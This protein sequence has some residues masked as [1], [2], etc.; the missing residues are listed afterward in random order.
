[1]SMRP[2]GMVGWL[3]RGYLGPQRWLL[4]AAL[5]LM[6]VEG[7]MAGTLSAL[8]RPMFDEVF[9]G[10]SARAV[11]WVAASVSGVFVIRALA[12]LGQRVLSARAG[13]RLTAA[14]QAD[15]VAHLATLDQRFHQA[16]PPGSLI[17]RVR[18]DTTALRSLLVSI[19]AALGRDAVALVSLFGVALWIDWRW[20]LVAVAGAPLLVLPVLALQ[21]LVRRTSRAARAAAATLSTRLDEIFHGMVTIQLTG[22]EAREAARYRAGLD[23]YVRDQ[24]RAEAG[25]AG[26]PAMMDI[27]AAIGFAGVLSYGGLQ[28]IAGEK[29]VGEFMS[30]FTAMALIFEP[31]R[32][33]GAVSGSWQVALANLERLR[34]LFDARP[35]VV[36]P[37]APLPLPA[38][39]PDIR[40]EQ[41]H[42]AY[43]R[44]PVLDG[45]D[46]VAEAGQTTALVGPSGAGKTTVFSLISRLADPQRGTVRLGGCDLRALD[47][48]GLRGL[49]SV[50]SQETALFDETIRDNILMGRS[51]VSAAALQ[52]AIDAA[53][54][55]EFAA[56]LPKGLDTPAGPRGSALSGGQRQRVAI[57]RAIL[58]DTPVLLLDEATSALDAQSEAL[59]AEALSRL[60]AG[61]TTLVI[62]HR[63]STVRD[64]DRI[65]VMERGRVVETGRHEE[66]LAR[67]GTYAGLYRLQFRPEAG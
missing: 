47:L 3:W 50:V 17:E 62:A 24:V 46:F 27:V 31:M 36:T 56:Q 14:M 18:G 34:T 43:G 37:A 65:V 13:E 28:I 22:T 6:A 38:G 19:V 52:A 35:T 21:R 66:L 29:T 16:N 30:F 41:V 10:G 48:R 1:M 32:R 64:A 51:G 5:L 12:G 39:A 45:L 40:F 15:L 53:H 60:S 42:F 7:S 8:I 57:A 67:D 61:R 55:A 33:L 11:T 58:R 20:T 59:V 25:S 63:L 49:I 44:E 54:V 4:L 23:G 9:V 26:I 2:A